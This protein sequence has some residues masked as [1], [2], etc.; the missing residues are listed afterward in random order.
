MPALEL[1]TPLESS[2]EGCCWLKTYNI[3]ADL[4]LPGIERIERLKKFW[5]EIESPNIVICPAN[6]VLN[7]Y[8]GTNERDEVQYAFMVSIVAANDRDYTEATAGWLL[9]CDW[10]VTQ[11]F[12]HQTTDIRAAKPDLPTG[13]MIRDVIVEP[14]AKY[15][16]P[17]N[18]ANYDASYVLVRYLVRMSRP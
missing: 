3:V 18:R 8:D 12:L 4:D 13:C 15:L 17:A 14:G 2:P 16:D 6:V 5:A 9:F 10:K 1:N 11:A 7:P